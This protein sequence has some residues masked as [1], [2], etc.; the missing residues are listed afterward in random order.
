MYAICSM[1]VACFGCLSGEVVVHW[2]L[3]WLV[4]IVGS[5]WTALVALRDNCWVLTTMACADCRKWVACSGT[6]VS[7]WSSSWAL[8]FVT[9]AYSREWVSCPGSYDW[10][11]GC[12]LTTMACAECRQWV[13]PLAG[14]EWK[15]LNTNCCGHW[16]LLIIECVSYFLPILITWQ[17]DQ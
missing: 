2:W 9:F 12:V 17:S 14:L 11:S 3:L 16:V 6:S 13:A 8:N 15:Y 10:G 4:L 7:K 1:W 5:E